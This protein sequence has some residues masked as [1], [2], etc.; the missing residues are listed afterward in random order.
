M[1][2][3]EY[4]EEKVMEKERQE[5]VKEGMEKGKKEGMNEERERMAT[6]L[7]KEGGMT[8]SFISRISM[9]SEEAVQKLA[10][11]MGIAVL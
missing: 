5:G 8:I 4:N 6:A 1:F 2:L 7:L 10:N 3:T 11:T 9:L